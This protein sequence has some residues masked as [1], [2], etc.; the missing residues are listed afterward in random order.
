MDKMSQLEE[1]ILN[2]KKYLLFPFETISY[3]LIIIIF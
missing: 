2:L 1:K 3:D